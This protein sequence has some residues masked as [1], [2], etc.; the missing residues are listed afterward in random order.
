MQDVAEATPGY[1]QYNVVGT[2]GQDRVIDYLAIN[3]TGYQDP[4]AI[5]LIGTH[6]GDEKSATDTLLGV[7]DYLLRHLEDPVIDKVM[8]YY[9]LYVLPVLNPDGHNAHTRGNAKGDDLNRDYAYPGM[10]ES[11]AF[12]TPETAALKHL[13]DDVAFSGAAAYHSGMRAILWPWCYSGNETED[14][15]VFYTIGKAIADAMGITY[16]DQSYNDFQSFG[17]FIDY[18]YSKHNTISLTVEVSTKKTPPAQE[19]Q[20]Y[21]DQVVDGAIAFMDALYEFDNGKLVLEE[22]P[23]LFYPDE[24]RSPI[25]QNGQRLE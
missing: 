25:D 11:E 9:A 15:D 20:G 18:T 2:S 1:I 16:I 10:D 8:D 13:L 3:L 7:I 19:L 23:E 6:H 12:Q 4:P 21:V 24:L 17:E 14:A 5:L 22:A